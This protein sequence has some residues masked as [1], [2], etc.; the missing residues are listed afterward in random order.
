MHR[1]FEVRYKECLLKSF[2]EEQLYYFYAISLLGFNDIIQKYSGL[3]SKSR[4]QILIA[5]YLQDDL[6]SEDE[7]AYLKTL[8]KE[9]YWFQSYHLIL[10]RQELLQDIENSIETFL[11]PDSVKLPKCNKSSKAQRE[12]HICR[13]TKKIYKRENLLF[14]TYLALNRQSRTIWN[15]GLKKVKR[16]LRT[17]K[18]SI[19][20]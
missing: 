9:Q 12:L 6:F 19:V 14:E 16:L 17:K 13:F 10:N 3:V 4:N 15:C 18:N 8:T 1:F 11:I 5:Y 2:N 20:S 7:V